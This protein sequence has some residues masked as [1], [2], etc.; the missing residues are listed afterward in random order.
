MRLGLIWLLVLLV[1]EIWSIISMSDYVGG[2]ATLVL[3]VAGFIFGLK[4]MRSQGLNAMMK[5]AQGVQPGESPL[6]PL[7]TG[8]VK[9]FAGILLIIPG[10]VATFSA[11]QICL[12]LCAMV[13]RVTSLKRASF[14]V[15]PM[16]ALVRM[17]LAVLVPVVSEKVDLVASV[18]LALPMK[19]ISMSM[20]ALQSL[21]TRLLKGKSS[22]ISLISRSSSGRAV[23][24]S[25]NRQNSALRKIFCAPTVE[26][27]NPN[28]TS[29]SLHS[30]LLY[31]SRF[32]W[33]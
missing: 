22:N 10:F 12:P 14:K 29:H 8:I 2:W 16:A 26:I 15:L 24:S 30:E 23:L 7:A 27:P 25:P 4:L 1:I 17:A 20:M 13:L 3:L 19:G 28:P 9:A 11:R 21:R 31:R 33:S 5:A 6:A 18:A 32:R